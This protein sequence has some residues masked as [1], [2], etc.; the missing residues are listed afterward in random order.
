[1]K[2]IFSKFSKMMASVL[3]LS[4]LVGGLSSA[5]AKPSVYRLTSETLR[6]HGIKSPEDVFAKPKSERKLLFSLRDAKGNEVFASTREYFVG[7]LTKRPSARERMLMQFGDGPKYT[8]QGS[9]RI[10][11]KPSNCSTYIFHPEALD[12][13]DDDSMIED[14]VYI[15][16]LKSGEHVAKF[17]HKPS[18]TN[19]IEI[20]EE[21]KRYQF[22]TVIISTTKGKV[23]V[24]VR[25]SRLDETEWQ[26]EIA[27]IVDGAET[28]LSWATLSTYPS[29][30]LMI[31]SEIFYITCVLHPE[32]GWTK[33]K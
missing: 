13:D 10:G 27:R 29:C 6:S 31:M 33:T 23:P 12:D 11:P 1:M 17:E 4:I 26:V 9:S 5:F 28:P 7:G 21:G 22:S 18:Y 15:K 3:S 2:N 32:T 30:R 16:E 25:V 19:T 20:L 24:T 14:M 8:L